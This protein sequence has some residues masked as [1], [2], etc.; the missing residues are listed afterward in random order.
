MRTFT[1]A[2]FVPRLKPIANSL[3]NIIKDTG[4]EGLSLA[5]K[6]R[7][8]ILATYLSNNASLNQS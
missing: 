8:V 7:I 3:W 5:V 4:Q 6:G 1:V 2:P